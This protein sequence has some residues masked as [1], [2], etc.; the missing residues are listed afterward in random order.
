MRIVIAGIDG[1]LGWPL[2]Q[3]LASHG[4]EIAGIDRFLRRAWVEEMGG[5]SAIPVADG[6]GCPTGSRLLVHG[7]GQDFAGSSSTTRS[8]PDVSTVRRGRASSP[9]AASQGASV[10][11]TT[12]R[13][14]CVRRKRTA[15]SADSSP[16]TSFW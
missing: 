8:P 14:S 15:A 3:H 12:K 7:E 13:T 2:A 10:A 16:I 5:E 4:H 1:Y 9:I 11:V 6:S